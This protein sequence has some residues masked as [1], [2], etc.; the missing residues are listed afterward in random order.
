MSEIWTPG[1]SPPS[2]PAGG[3]E[4][5]KGFSTSRRKEPEQAETTAETTPPADQPPPQ[6]PETAS[7]QPDEPAATPQQPELNLL[8]P[9]SG[10]QINCP[11]CSTTY[12]VA[13]FSIVDFG[14]NPELRSLVLGGQLNT[15]SCSSC[16]AGGPLSVPLMIHDPE[17]EFLGV[18]APG[19]ARV[20]DAQLQKTIGD[21]SQALMGKLPSDQRKGYMFQAQQF[22]NWDSLIEKLWGFQGVTP[23]MLR[24]RREQSELIGS[25]VR[26]NDDVPAMQL[27]VDRKKALVDSDFFMLMGQ[28]I[29]ALEAEG[30]TEQ[31]EAFSNLQAH[32]LETTE[33]GREIKAVEGRIEEALGKLGPRTTREDLLSILLEYWQEGE[34]GETIAMALLNAA[35]G[36]TDYQFLLGLAERLEKTTDP[37]DRSALIALR[38]RIV[39][40]NEQRT[41]SQQAAVQQMQT[42]LQEVLQAPD[43]DAALQENADQVNEMF[44]ALLAT[45]IKQAEQNNA[46]FAVQRLRTIYTKA[47]AMIEERMPP[48]LKLLN[49]LLGAPDEG[50]LR[51][52]MQDNRS[53]FSQEFIEAM[54]TLETRFH[55]EGNNTLASRVRS[56]RGQATLML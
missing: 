18:I 36:L 38:E 16:G 46:T 2:Q 49:Q 33:A 50:T 53:Q 20:D 17:N 51:R 6:P 37:E 13:V 11:N 47:I 15:A 3:I 27:V 28:V 1:S 40:M 9:P 55:A 29:N 54:K 24:H 12:S 42:V 41:Q 43:T 8:F 14:A 48:E 23:E 30:R 19:Q 45:N 7:R 39:E 56:I 26:L 35:A 25:L 21:L 5:P 22:L 10:A 52:L 4:L 34:M 32:L 31:V 44:L